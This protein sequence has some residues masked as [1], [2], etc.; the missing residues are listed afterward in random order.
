MLGLTPEGLRKVLRGEVC[1]LGV[2]NRMR[3]D[4]GAGPALVDRIAGR[5]GAE[6]VDAGMAPENYLEVVVKKKPDTVL[7]VDAVEFG[8]RP[9]EIRV[10]EA[11]DIAGGGLSTHAASLGLACE[12]LTRRTSA[13]IFLAAI[14]PGSSRLGEPVSREVGEAI[15]ALADLLS[16]VLPVE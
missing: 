13:A 7:V 3:G 6:V 14:Q 15:G 16:E 5:V 11:G 8:G 4:D 12:Y 9:G 1:I 10:L 2:G